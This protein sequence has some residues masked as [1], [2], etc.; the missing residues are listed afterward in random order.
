MIIEKNYYF[1]FCW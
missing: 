1:E